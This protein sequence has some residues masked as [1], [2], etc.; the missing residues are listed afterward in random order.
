MQKSLY[1]IQKPY[2]KV[3]ILIF[4][5]FLCIN[6]LFAEKP[7]GKVALFDKA[8]KSSGSDEVLVVKER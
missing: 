6:H 3:I 7:I 2:L 4:M 1:I 5:F 8:V